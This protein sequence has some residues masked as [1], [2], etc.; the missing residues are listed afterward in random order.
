LPA[1]SGIVNPYGSDPLVP[2]ENIGKVNSSGFEATL[3]YSHNTSDFS[4]GLSGN[5]TYAKSKVIFVDEASGALGYQ[6]QTDRPL[7]TYLLYKAVGIFRSQEQLDAT[8]H[9]TGA[10][11]GDVILEDYNHDGKIT[12][13]DQ[14]RSKYGN[15]PEITYGFSFNAAYRQFDLSVL[16]AGQTHV[17]QY[18]LPE[19]GTIGNFYSSWAD[20]R[21][22]PSNPNGSYPR[23]S[24][25]ASS[26]I[27]GGLY[28]NTFWLNNASFLRLK[29][30]Q[31]GYNVKS[32]FLSKIKVSGLR[33]YASAFNLFTITKVKDY[34]PEGTSGS[35]QFYP[36]Q[37]II[38]LGV[39][40]KF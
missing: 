1:T 13:D 38:N 30:I 7:N 17:S 18:V 16:F 20:N 15:I 33:V 28:P 22:S 40:V 3:G 36:Q 35:G 23:V 39:N 24:D 14:V 2:S 19:S 31:L 26:A 4:W 37:K 29:N 8:P 9:V 25:R 12:A 34:D 11:V 10:Q 5:I 21:Y 32:A 27:S 6:R